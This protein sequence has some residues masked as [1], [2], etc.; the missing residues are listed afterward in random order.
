M[1]RMVFLRITKLYKSTKRVSHGKVIDNTNLGLMC[2]LRISSKV[3][4]GVR[5]STKMFQ[6][7]YILL[8]SPSCVFLGYF[9]L[10]LV[11]HIFPVCFHFFI[12]ILYLIVK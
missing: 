6:Y 5:N 1:T 7:V 11:F 9:F 4:L 8:I 10:N 3:G 2:I 12:F